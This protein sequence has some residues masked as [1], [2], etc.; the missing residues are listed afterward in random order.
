MKLQLAIIFG[1]VGCLCSVEGQTAS[2]DF[3][4][5]SEGS[6]L[7]VPT[8]G[9]LANDTGGNL[10]AIL[11]TGPANGMLTLNADGSFLYTPTNNFT[12]VDGFTYRANN[13]S[14]TSGVASVD[15]M[16]LAP[17]QLFYDNF[18]RLTNNGS[19]FPW[20]RISGAVAPGNWGVSTVGGTWSITNGQMQGT[21][22]NYTY[23]YTYC[24][25]TNWT[26]YSVQGQIRF[27][28]NTA[29]S[30]GIMGRV[31][32]VTGAHYS[33]Y[34]YPERSDEYNVP[35]LHGIPRLWLYKYESWTS[36]TNIGQWSSLPSVGTNLHALK[37]T[38]LGNNILAYFDGNLV[39]NVTDNGS[40]DGQPAY[41]HGAVGLNLWISTTPYVFSV[42]NIIVTNLVATAGDDT[43]TITTATGPTLNVPAP[44]ILANDTGNGPL[45]ALLVSGPDNGNLNLTNNGGFSYS[46]T[47]GFFGTD[48]FTYQCT[49]GQTTSS[50]AT[51]AIVVSN[52]VFDLAIGKSGSATIPVTSNLVYAISVTNI[53]PSS[54]NNV[55]VMDALPPGVSF[56]SA[57]G[58]WV[59]NSGGVTWSLGTLTS[60]QISNV[61][62]TIMAPV[63]GTLTNV[64]SVGP[65][66][67]DTNP[68]NN[69]TPPVITTVTPLADLGL[70]RSGP[71]GAVYGANFNYTISV[72][73]FGPSTATSVS[74]TDNV[75]AGLVFVA[76]SADWTTNGNQVIWTNLESLVSGMTTNLTLTVN[77]SSVGIVTNIVSGSSA[78][79]DP[80]L[81]NNEALPVVTTITKAP[82]AVTWPVPTNIVY[83]TP[84]GTN[85]NDGTSSVPGSFVYNPTNGTMLTAGT[86]FLYVLFMPTDTNYETTNLSVQ[87]VVLPA[88]AADG[89]RQRY[90]QDLRPDGD[91]CRDGIQQQRVV[92]WR[93]GEQRDVEQQRRG[94]GGERGRFA[95]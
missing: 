14:K 73:N 26:D 67:N 17:G 21:G 45:A 77:S 7:S 16:V 8:P 87:L 57:S 84:L 23:G 54:A 62:L 70:G 90:K 22:T 38:F 79:P 75:P 4:S 93:Y 41:T 47:N 11:T 66:S 46:P 19:I 69:V 78:T 56:V 30:A 33:V 64:A 13:G 31:N 68:A 50:V 5:V 39:T 12:G 34:I 20:T 6:S 25:S 71:A 60:G 2:N 59:T 36:Y 58:S 72:T 82:P 52:A 80:N 81:T 28:R 37:L 86:N 3:Y 9:V 49:D 74:V 51:V 32:P 24:G 85:Q 10:T 53:G 27:S 44:G 65:L 63:S 48:S 1:V 55:T 29:S 88:L 40:I 91:L 42:D 15:I 43:Y 83:G 61:L 76:A 35:P 92:E 95:V 89:E 94:S 18:S